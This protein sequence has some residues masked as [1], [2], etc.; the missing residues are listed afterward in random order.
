[1]PSILQ[2][3][4]DGGDLETEDPPNSEVSRQFL[5]KFGTSAPLII[6]LE[7]ALQYDKV[8]ISFLSGMTD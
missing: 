1:V 6:D 3:I 4:V 7:K 8:G 2:S 5:K